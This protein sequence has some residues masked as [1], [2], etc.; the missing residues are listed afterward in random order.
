MGIDPRYL[1]MGGQM[2]ANVLALPRTMQN[3]RQEAAM[4]QALMGLASGQ[5]PGPEAFAAFQPPTTWTDKLT[6]GVGDL[7]AALSA[8]LGN[9]VPAPR[10][11]TNA[12]ATLSKARQDAESR[13]SLASQYKNP[14]AQSLVKA[15]QYKAAESAETGGGIG[16]GSEL[17]QMIQANIDAGM[18]MVQARARAL[19]DYDQRQKGRIQYR[20]GV[21]LDTQVGAAQGRAAIED[22]QRGE[23]EDAGRGFLDQYRRQTPAPTPTPPTV[24]R[25]PPRAVPH[26]RMSYTLLDGT[27]AEPEVPRGGGLVA[28]GGKQQVGSATVTF[29]NPQIQKRPA[30]W[31]NTAQTLDPPVDPYTTDPAEIRRVEAALMAKP[32]VTAALK[33][34]GVQR[35]KASPILAQL[36]RVKLAI[37]APGIDGQ[38]LLVSKPAPGGIP[39]LSTVKTGMD[40]TIN[41]NRLRDLEQAGDPNVKAMK[42]FSLNM[43]GLAKA[44]GDS[45]NISDTA[46][47]ILQKYATGLEN[48]TVQE[49]EQ[50]VLGVERLLQDI[51]RGN[52]NVLRDPAAGNEQNLQIME[53]FGAEAGDPRSQALDQALGLQ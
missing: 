12:L 41:A 45:G 32:G 20:G 7:G 46:I 27:T 23:R 36:D 2:L 26:E 10:V 40:T 13:A 28:T 42:L 11:D 43:A 5:Q 53:Q 1:M 14:R 33:E 21:S 49:A 22:T 30:Q 34:R 25:L 39:Y 52:P 47:E 24:D 48:M 8:V 31:M 17:T 44:L 35:A 37:K 9:P 15:G 50:T 29:D 51:T 38:P 19:A 4:Q 3:Q 16:T 6:S 18:P